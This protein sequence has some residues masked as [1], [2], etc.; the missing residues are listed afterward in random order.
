MNRLG[1][2]LLVFVSSIAKFFVCELYSSAVI[3]EVEVI[4]RGNRGPRDACLSS[5]GTRTHCLTSFQRAS[6]GQFPRSLE[7]G[8]DRPTTSWYTVAASEHLLVMLMA[9][10]PPESKASQMVSDENGRR[11]VGRPNSTAKEFS[12]NLYEPP[13]GLARTDDRRSRAG[14]F[15]RALARPIG[16]NERPARLS[17]GWA[18]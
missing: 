10:V 7:T 9:T 6:S 2:A 13:R 4:K 15:H 12:R 14:L 1:D 18:A 3:L 17:T 5:P 11:S 8:A 16:T